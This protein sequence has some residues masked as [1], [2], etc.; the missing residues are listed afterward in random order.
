MQTQ[1]FLLALHSL[2]AC[3]EPYECIASILQSLPDVLLL[4]LQGMSSALDI[5]AMLLLPMAIV[6]ATYALAI[7]MIR[8]RQM[9]QTEVRLP[10]WYVLC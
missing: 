4:P 5:T 2:E 1:V 9:R 10:P 3:N 8:L 7:Y 6:I